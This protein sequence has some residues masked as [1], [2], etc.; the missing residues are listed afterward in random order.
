[1]DEETG[2]EKNV[3]LIG[4]D[5]K[6]PAKTERSFSTVSDGQTGVEIVVT[7]SSYPE[8]DPNSKYVTKIWEGCLELNPPYGKKGRIINV[9]FSYDENQMMHCKFLDTESVHKNEVEVS[10]S[11]A[12]S[13]TGA[14]GHN[15]AKLSVK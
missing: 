8:T 15:I 7:E 9:T 10:L 2:R 3:V 14:V 13:A 4:K 1:M 6:I 11:M 12:Q 5:T